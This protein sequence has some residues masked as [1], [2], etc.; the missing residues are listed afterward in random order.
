[1]RSELEAATGATLADRLG[2]EDALVTAN[3]AGAVLL[4]AGATRT[5]AAP[6][7]RTLVLQLGHLV[8]FCAPL[9]L[10]LRMAGCAPRLVGT[11]D[12]CVE[13]EVAPAL[14]AAD[15][16]AALFVVRER[17]EPGLIDLPRWLW[18]CHAAARPVI[19]VDA[20]GRD[21]EARLD[22]GADLLALDGRALG[23]PAAG[24]LAGKAELIAAAAAALDAIG[25]PGRAP[26]TLLA[27]FAAVPTG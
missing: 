13:A 21:P 26:D 5:V 11:V 10:L 25:A 27:A 20:L 6:E 16:A 18:A 3:L 8:S 1:M 23:L 24:I 14:R 19:V 15:V 2:A 17:P 22:A 9:D 7:R 4:A 12:R